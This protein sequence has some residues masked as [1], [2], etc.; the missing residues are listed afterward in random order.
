[1]Q[2][3]ETV[4]EV[5]A[6]PQKVWALLHSPPPPD[7]PS[8]RLVTYPGGWMNILLEGDANGQGMVRNCEFGV[9]RY[10]LSKG[11]AHSWEIVTE[12]RPLEFASYE[13]IGKPLWSKANGS[14]TLTAL[15]D[16]GTRLTF[17]ESY[18]VHNPVL[19]ALLEKRVHAYISRDNHKLYEKILGYLGTVKHVSTRSIAVAGASA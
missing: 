3:F 9:P 18:H 16:G 12:V 19:R 2:R 1:V 13:A 17:V 15:P 7:A 11:K 14:H 8:P 6:S 4:F 10:L 5:A